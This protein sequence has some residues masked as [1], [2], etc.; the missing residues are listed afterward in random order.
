MLTA[1]RKLL[2]KLIWYKC[3]VVLK[4]TPMGRANTETNKI[5]VNPQFRQI[6]F[7]VR[8]AERV[9]YLA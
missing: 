9:Y 1:I 6:A 4:L 2:I 8:Y 7:S 5:R 3:E